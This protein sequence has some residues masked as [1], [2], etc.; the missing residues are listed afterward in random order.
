MLRR[1]LKKALKHVRPNRYVPLN[2]I[3]ISKS[4]ALNN[5]NLIKNKHKDYGIIPV[6][7][8]N[9]YG[10]GLLQ[11]AEIL[12]DTDCDFVAVDGYFE[13]SG[14]RDVTRHNILVMGFIRPENVHLLDTKRCSFVVQDTESLIALAHLG[15][16]VRIH[17]ELN[18]GMNRLGLQPDE[19]DEYLDTLKQFPSL[20]LEG[21]MSHLA[22][23]DNEIDNRFTLQQ[24]ET[25]NKSVRHILDKGFEPRFIHL[26]QTAGSTKA[27]SEYTNAIRM[28]IGLYGLNPLAVNDAKYPELVDL[29]PVLEF[30]STII[31]VIGLK[32]GDRVS[33]NGIFTAREDMKIGVL[34]LGYYEGI[35]RALSNAGTVLYNGRPL[36]IVGRVC[37]N[38]TMIDLEDT[39]AKVGSEIKVIS[40]NSD[41]PNSVNKICREHNLF[42]YSFATGLASATRRVIVP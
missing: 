31:K 26:A 37:M 36:K 11:M 23:A 14:I 30:K 24:V 7:K 42:N 25:F 35:P 40:S 38:H 27:V 16:Q 9:A 13:A 5:V 17:A 4:A 10:H 8:A 41:E 3:E 15:K 39:D 33:Y 32:K 18:T 28:G 29:Q 34:P 20:K 6:L 21:I 1:N 22:D 2:Q 12:N 19:L